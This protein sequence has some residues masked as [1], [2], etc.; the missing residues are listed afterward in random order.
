MSAI[1]SD[2][3][4]AFSSQLAASS[5]Q[6]PALSSQRI[7]MRR[8]FNGGACRRTARVR[9]HPANSE[10]LSHRHM[11]VAPRQPGTVALLLVFAVRGLRV[12]QRRYEYEAADRVTEEHRY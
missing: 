12:V 9:R 3:D 10:L 4:S 6:R 2:T 1:R 8:L 11:H 5:C 7:H